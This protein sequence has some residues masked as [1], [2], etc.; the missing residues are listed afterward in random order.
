MQR[1]EWRLKS[2]Q[3][4][5]VP[6]DE[7]ELIETKF[8]RDELSA[9]MSRVMVE[10]ETKYYRRVEHAK[11]ALDK[12]KEIAPELVPK[13]EMHDGSIEFSGPSYSLPVDKYYEMVSPL[14][15]ANR[16][17]QM[18]TLGKNVKTIDED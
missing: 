17:E 16:Y 10:E 18:P 14:G 9:E 2:F 11:V 3:R 13:P 12:L 5:F 15:I 8:A 7:D 4:E 1:N 6:F